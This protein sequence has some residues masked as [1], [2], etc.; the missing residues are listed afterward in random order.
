MLPLANQHLVDQAA[1]R[2]LDD[3]AVLFYLDHAG[4]NYCAC[5][6]CSDAPCTKTKDQ[7]TEA[8][9]SKPK[10]ATRGPTWGHATPP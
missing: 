5:E 7:R 10:R 8:K 1:V 2:V 4:G 6:F 9:V 3:L